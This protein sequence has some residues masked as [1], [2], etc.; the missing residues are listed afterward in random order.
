VDPAAVER[1]LS[2]KAFRKGDKARALEHAERALTL[3]EEKQDKYNLTFFQ[4]EVAHSLREQG[5]SAE[6]LKFY[7]RTDA[8]PIH[9]H[10]PGANAGCRSRRKRESPC[11]ARR[12]RQHSST[13][14]GRRRRWPCAG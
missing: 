13:S 3:M 7:R 2:E 10:A 12:R 8:V 1:E 5:D 14:C 6:A 4:S 9:G 11:R